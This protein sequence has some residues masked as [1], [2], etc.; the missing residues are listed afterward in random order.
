MYMNR[1]VGTAALI[2]A[3]STDII[4][5]FLFQGVL[6]V[7]YYSS[8]VVD[9]YIARSQ[10]RDLGICEECGGLNDPDTCSQ[11]ACPS[12]LDS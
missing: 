11:A 8:G 5:F 1:P 3:C 4:F 6:V 10:R 7:A 9:A 2:H 12:N